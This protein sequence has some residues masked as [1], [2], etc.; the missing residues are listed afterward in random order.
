MDADIRA[1]LPNIDPIVSDYSVGYLN[2][3]STLY[4]DDEDPS[5]PSPLDEAATTIR[6]I[7][8][9]A[10]GQPDPDLERNITE[11]VKKWVDRYTEANGGQRTGPAAVRR[12][13]Q[14]IQVSSQRNMSSTLAVASGGVDLESANARKVESKVDRKKLE[15][16]ERKIAAKQQKKT[17]KTVEYEASRLLDQ[18]EDTQSYEEFYMAVNPLQLGANANKTKDITL[19]NIDVSI[20]GLRIL[21]DTTLTL[22]YGHRYGLVGKNGIGKSTLLRAL[23][24]REVA[25]PTHISILHVEQEITGDDTPAIQ[26]VLDADVWRKVLL[27]EQDVGLPTSTCEEATLTMI[28]PH[29][30]T[31]SFGGQ[32]GT[33]CRHFGRRG[34]ARP[35]TRGTG[36]EARRCPREARRDGL[37]QGRVESSQYPGRSRLLSRKTTI[38]YKDLLRWLEDASRIGES[39]VLRAGP[40]T[41]RRTVQ[42]VGRSIHYLPF[43]LPANVPQHGAH[44]LPRQSV[45]ERGRHRHCTPAL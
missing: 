23:S 41:S 9:S 43:Q 31:R 28:G 42:H 5:G 33:T 1:V 39:P 11:L 13:D 22:A 35:R 4:S 18:P 24:R 2:H 16:A 29:G 25:I 10:S 30:K 3:A 44:R 38:R 20:G 26:A 32:E 40:P 7:L 37:G 15:K 17:F 12:L 6:E 14:T 8:L 19:D 27:R 36:H 45:P 34:Q 21:T